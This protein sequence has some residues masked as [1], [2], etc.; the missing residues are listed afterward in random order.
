[1]RSNSRGFTLIELLVVIAIIGILASVVLIAL[2]DARQKGQD[3]NIMKTINGLRPHAEIYWNDNTKSYDAICADPTILLAQGNISNV[4][5]TLDCEEDSV[6]GMWFVL[7]S[8]LVH[9]PTNYYCVDNEGFAG[10]ITA[11]PVGPGC[12]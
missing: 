8:P 9:E 11:A 10:V 3:A 1:M 12:N 7:S 6:N 4:G 5:G 2:N